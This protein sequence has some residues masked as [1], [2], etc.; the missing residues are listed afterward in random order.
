M[1]ENRKS[2][3]GQ[4]GYRKGMALALLCEHYGRNPNFMADFSGLVTQHSGNLEPIASYQ[5]IERW[6]SPDQMFTFWDR[7]ASMGELLDNPQCLAAAL[8]AA[9]AIATKW[10]LNTRWAPGL[11]VSHAVAREKGSSKFPIGFNRGAA[12]L[13]PPMREIDSSHWWKW[14]LPRS[15]RIEDDGTWVREDNAPRYRSE[16]DVTWVEDNSI[17]RDSLPQTVVLPASDVV[18]LE[19][20]QPDHETR[21]EFLTRAREKLTQ[22][23]LVIED[24]YRE[25]GGESLKGKSEL[26]KHAE[27]LY[28]ALCPD[29]KKGRPL[30]FNEIAE[31]FDPKNTGNPG[32]DVVGKE[33]RPLADLLGLSLSQKPGRPAM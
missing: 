13:F 30:R 22:E 8:E 31:L 19:S 5:H 6:I 32:A 2:A 33:V 3:L 23:A 10:G 25:R 28:L 18:L 12:W 24:I 1:V 9:G 7:Y 4:P 27:W 14:L 16:D 26:D 20:Y 29:V 11:L 17:D 15:Y 21:K